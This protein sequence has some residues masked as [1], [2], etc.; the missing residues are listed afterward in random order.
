MEGKPRGERRADNAALHRLMEGLAEEA[1]TLVGIRQDY[2][3][4][5]AALT[6]R[7]ETF[8]GLVWDRLG[9]TAHKLTAMVVIVAAACVIS[10]AGLGLVIRQQSTIQDEQLAGRRFAINALCGATSGVIDAGR[11]IIMAGGRTPE[12]KALARLAAISYGRRI[13]KT[14][15]REIGQGGIVNDDGTLNCA[16]LR[17]RAAAS[18]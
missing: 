1:D 9:K 10:L 17:L 13:A 16:A 3:E 8:E 18:K 11:A 5:T 14:T 6:E 15:E 4:F 2:A 7:Q 12:Q